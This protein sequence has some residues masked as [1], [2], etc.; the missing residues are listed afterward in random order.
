L[1]YVKKYNI[2][3]DYFIVDYFIAIAYDTLSDIRIMIDSVPGNN[4]KVHEFHHRLNPN[5]EFN[6]TLFDDLC[7]TTYFHKLNWKEEFKLH[8]SNGKLTNY[9]YI[10]EKFVNS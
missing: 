3:I 2:L 1:A 8:T 5:F 6:K 4:P 7:S 9:G 10:I